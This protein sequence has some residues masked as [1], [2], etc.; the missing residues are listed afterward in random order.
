MCLRVVTQ[1]SAPYRSVGM[2][3]EEYIF[4]F[5]WL[6]RSWLSKILRRSLPKLT[7]VQLIQGLISL[8]IVVVDDRWLPRYG[9]WE[10]FRR[11]VSSILKFCSEA[12]LFGVDWC[13]AFVFLTLMVK[14]IFVYVL[15]KMSTITCISRAQIDIVRILKLKNHG[16]GCFCQSTERPDVKE[17]P[18]YLLCD[19]NSMSTP[20]LELFEQ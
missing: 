8:S 10:T 15:T 14:P 3:T 16:S 7:L 5:V 9:K 2:A 12:D 18:V 6:V 11:A 1:F 13:K 20:V 19:V 17:T 4:T